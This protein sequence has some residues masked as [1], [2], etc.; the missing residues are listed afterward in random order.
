MTERRNANDRRESI[1]SRLDL[2]EYKLS[3]QRLDFDEYVTEFN[4]DKKE[5][6]LLLQNLTKQQ[7]KTQT[8]LGGATLLVTAVG[9]A[10]W[11]T[12]KEIFH[13]IFI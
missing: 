5:T 12:F 4:H 1:E 3:Q 7:D 8:I 6:L 2:L 11:F 9:S 13:K 10:I